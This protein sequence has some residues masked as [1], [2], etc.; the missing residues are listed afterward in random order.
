MVL[1]DQPVSGVLSAGRWWGY[2][3][4]Q[5]GL[6]SVSFCRDEDRRDM[7]RRRRAPQRV[8][9]EVQYGTRA[10]KRKIEKRRDE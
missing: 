4:P 1:T 6:L 2:S 10:K 8:L 5:Q 7:R 9:W 3:A